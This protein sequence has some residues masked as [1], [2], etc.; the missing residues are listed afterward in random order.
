MCQ[1]AQDKVLKR[2]SMAQFVA[3]LEQVFHEM[4]GKAS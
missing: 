1:R 2:Y 4:A 3:E